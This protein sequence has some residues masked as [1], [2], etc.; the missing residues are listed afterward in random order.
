[1]ILHLLMKETDT[2]H[3]CP[4]CLEEIELGSEFCHDTHTHYKTAECSCC[5]RTVNVKVDFS[6]SGDD[7]Y[8]GLESVIRH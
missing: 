5:G 7:D 2:T 1:M 8:K 4:Y 6:G 3:L